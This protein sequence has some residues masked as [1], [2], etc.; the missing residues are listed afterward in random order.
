MANSNGLSIQFSRIAASWLKVVLL[1]HTNSDGL[2]WLRECGSLSWVLSR[3]NPKL[4]KRIFCFLIPNHDHVS[5]TW[6]II[7]VKVTGRIPKKSVVCLGQKIQPRGGV[8]LARKRTCSLML[9]AVPAGESQK[10]KIIAPDDTNL[11]WWNL[12]V[13][14][15]SDC[16]T[17]KIPAIFYGKTPIAYFEKLT[18]SC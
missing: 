13:S 8:N 5:C 12:V 16:Y 4:W 6:R 1:G 15:W 11:M 3:G 18:N 10:L 17:G 9:D 2:A 14:N 7:S